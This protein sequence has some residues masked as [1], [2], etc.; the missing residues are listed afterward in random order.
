M[1]RHNHF[2]HFFATQYPLIIPPPNSSNWKIKEFLKWIK[3]VSKKA[4]IL[5]KRISVDEQTT[6]FQGRHSSKLRITYKKEG[7]GFQ[8]DALCDDG[9]TFTFYFCHE[10]PP[11]E[12]TSAGLFPLHARVMSLF[13]DVND[14]YQKCGV[15]NLYM[16][17]K[18]CRY[19]YNHT[20]R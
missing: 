4:R 19:A 17:A 9:Y 1:R 3:R 15:D 10:P 16:Y 14:E 12:Y 7:D 2:R 20:K 6:G 13:D 8:Y 5:A 11:V 18:F